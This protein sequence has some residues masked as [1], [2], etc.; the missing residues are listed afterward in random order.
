MFSHYFLGDP[1]QTGTATLSITVIDVNDNFPVF[2][3]DYRPVVYENMKNG[4]DGVS[5]PL[6]VSVAVPLVSLFFCWRKC[7]YFE[8]NYLLS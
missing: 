2:K 5:F 7:L 4:K 3:E 6:H 8:P 1:Q